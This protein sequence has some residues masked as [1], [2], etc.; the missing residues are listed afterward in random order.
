MTAVWPFG[1]LAPG[2]ARVI[3]ADP[4]WLYQTRSAKGQGRSPQRHYNCMPITDIM[5]MPVVDLAARHCALFLWI[6]KTMLPEA[7]D[8]IRAWG[9]TYKTIAFT[10]VKTRPSGKEFINTGYWTRGNPELCLLATRGR[11]QRL[12]RD[13]RELVEDPDEWGSDV[14]YSHIREHSRKPDEIRDRIARLLGGPGQSQQTGDLVE[15]FARTRMPGWQCWGNQSDRFPVV[16]SAAAVRLD[17]ANEGRL[18]GRKTRFI[19]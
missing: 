2:S 19:L 14:L 11:P 18:A 10:W 16:G 4:P 3:Y 1:A 17:P 5:A 6:S 9:F 15:L 12:G 8:V 7:L 13:V